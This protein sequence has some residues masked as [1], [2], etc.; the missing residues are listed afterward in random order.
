MTTSY[1][2]LTW[3]IW[4]DEEDP[5]GRRAA[6]VSAIAACRPDVVA[7]QEVPSSGL[8]DMASELSMRAAMSTVAPTAAA[9]DDQCR[10]AI[11]SRWPIGEARTIHLPNE[12][13]DIVRSA[14]VARTGPAEAIT[15][16]SLHLSWGPHH[17]ELRRRQ[18]DAIAD[19]IISIDD[20]PCVLAGDFN[21]PPDS[22]DLGALANSG[23]TD[24]WPAAQPDDPGYTWRLDNPHAARETW[25]WRRIDLIWTRSPTH[26]L[27][28]EKAELIGTGSI[29]AVWPS[30]HAG[31]LVGLSVT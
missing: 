20:R 26:R 31:V 12:P 24:A 19:A 11:L 7:L 1:R 30:D 16:A 13:T 3:N 6:I 14:I 28:V 22:P 9:A 21:A 27:L 18:T 25:P 15:I 23:F 4:G 8:A 17:M 10:V 5:V 29:G 2:V